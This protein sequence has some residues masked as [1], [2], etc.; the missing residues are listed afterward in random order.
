MTKKLIILSIYLL[1]YV[2]CY[3]MIKKDIMSW[4][5]SKEWTVG[6]RKHA[7]AI[8]LFSWIGF[9]ASGL[10]YLDTT[11]QDNRPAKW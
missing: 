4:T 6:D 9:A 3:L 5:T 8:S 10:H 7:L 11:C 1:G 2:S